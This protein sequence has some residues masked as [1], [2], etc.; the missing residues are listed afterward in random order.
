MHLIVFYCLQYLRVGIV[1][2]EAQSTGLSCI[3]S[4]R[5]PSI[6]NVTNSVVYLPLDSDRWVQE[7]L[8]SKY[9]IDESQSLSC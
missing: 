1:A 4:D 7:I 9:S 2:I 5:V 6:T 3:L 8:K